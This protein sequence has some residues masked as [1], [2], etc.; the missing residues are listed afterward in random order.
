[1]ALKSQGFKMNVL[2]HDRNKN[3]V[4]ETKLNAR[5][6]DLDFLLKNSDII[7]IHLPLN[8][9]THHLIQ[10]KQLQ[11]MKES[12]VIIN[13]ARGP[14]IKEDDLV[15]SLQQKR[16]FGAGLDVYEYEP[17]I[18]SKLI[19]QKNVV[20]LPHIG[21]ATYETRSNM[22]LIAAQNLLDGMNGIKPKNCIN[23][24]IF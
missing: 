6:V 1:M 16:I 5:K 19:E 8:E 9:K 20:L 22:A 12:A 18:G 21:S 3:P 15:E 17:K 7:S 24:E 4:L 2:Y 23:P 14:I 13:T 10:S 11:K